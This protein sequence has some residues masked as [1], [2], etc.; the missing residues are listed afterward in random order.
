MSCMKKKFKIILPFV[1]TSIL[2]LAIIAFIVF[3]FVRKKDYNYYLV[4]EENYYLDANNPTFNIGIYSNHQHDYY[5]NSK[6]IN[7]VKIKNGLNDEFYTVKLNQ[8]VEEDSIKVYQEKEYYKYRLNITLP[9]KEI[10]KFQMNE[11]LLEFT[12]HSEEKMTLKIG[13]LIIY[14]PSDN[15]H[16]NISAMKGIVNPLNNLQILCGIGISLKSNVDLI[17]KKI[18][19]LDDRV[20][21]KMN[22]IKILDKTDYQNSTNLE[23][24]LEGGRLPDFVLNDPSQAIKI[25]K[26]TNYHYVLPLTY[27]KL[28]TINTL[29]FKII[30]EYQNV[31]YEYLIN[32]FKFFSTTAQDYQV[33][34]YVATNS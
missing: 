32:P 3:S 28:T 5:L 2:G 34:K 21:L 7:N 11:T 6:T 14:K 24:L 27:Q 31:E 23:E 10:D 8:I 20:S 1:I 18:I 19:I 13:S 9:L 12:Y 17:M 4:S 22:E 29:A 15:L 25:S 16:L 33:I 26:N 30:Y